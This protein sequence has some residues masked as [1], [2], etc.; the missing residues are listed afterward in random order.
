MSEITLS[1]EPRPLGKSGLHVSPL[2]WGMWRFGGKTPDEGRRLIEAAFAAGI[3]LFDTADI[4][5]FES[6]E[7]GFGD[8]ETLLGQIFAEAP[9]LRQKMVLAT[10]G[11]ITPPV[12]YDSSRDYLMAALDAS[13]KRLG[14]DH[15]DLYQV[16]RPDILTHPRDLAATLDAMVASG[17]VRSVGVS[18]VT[19]DQS[20]AL[21]SFL[22]VPLVQPAARS[23][24]RSIWSR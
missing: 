21:A 2:A 23:S 19:P 18:N 8:A 1:P 24:R 4:Y 14:V 5:G 6:V 7:K 17:K 10:K 15:V 12:P 20:R 22:T 9:A 16:H 3:T 11:G 13:L